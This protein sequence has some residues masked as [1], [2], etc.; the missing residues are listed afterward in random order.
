M[1]NAA[2]LIVSGA[3][4]GS[5]FLVAGTATATALPSCTALATDPANGL[6][7]N[8]FV[9]S[10]NSA[11]IPPSGANASYCQV[12]ILYGENPNQNIN[13]RVGLP[14]SSLDG[15]T[16]GVQGAWNGRTQGVGGGGCTGNLT[17][18]TAPVNARYVGSGTDGG[19]SGAANNCEPAVNLDGTYNVQYI[20]DWS[21]NG[22]K[23]QILFSKALA[24]AYYGEAPLYNYWNGCSTGGRQGYLLAQELGNELDGILANAPAI[25]WTRFQTAQMWG[26]IVMKDLTGGVIPT[27]KQNFA[28]SKATDACDALDGVTDGI[29]DDPRACTY[30]AAHDP[31][32]ICIANGGTSADPNCLTPAQA[33]AMDKIW[34]GPRNPSGVK[35]WFHSEP[36]SGTTVWNGPAPFPLGA[37]QFH[38][39]EQDRN[40]DWHTVTMFGAGGTDSYADIAYD[41]STTALDPAVDPDFSLADATDTFGNLDTFQKHGGK[42][43]TFVGGYDNFIMPRGVIN[44]YREMASRYGKNPNKPDFATLQNFYRLFRAPGVG[45]CGGGVGPQPQNLFGALVNWVE[46]GVAPATILAQGGAVP[47]R[48]RPLCPYPT[49]AIYNGT[50]STDDAANFHCGGNLETP[51]T[52]CKDVLAKYKHENEVDTP[53]DY[54]NTGVNRNICRAFLGTQYNNP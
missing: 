23:E 24:D 38:W 45:H 44:Y 14:L 27:A 32:A 31:T 25:Y 22:I 16:G 6:A 8:P 5:A 4:L 30:S 10:A 11:I 35:I 42:L 9:K 20:Q 54:S 15:G 37:T 2:Y 36:G 26:Q 34:D 43:L 33:Q 41:G 18:V 29:I 50:G 3:M 51:A 46:N 40:F 39:D 7:G 52:V 1:R 13:I 53:V 28:T 49:T 48:T 17:G 47:T 12:N 21:R 19:H